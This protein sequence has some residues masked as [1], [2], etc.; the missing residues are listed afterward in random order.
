MPRTTPVV[1]TGDEKLRTEFNDF[2]W[3]DV[4]LSSD[5]EVTNIPLPYTPLVMG[6]EILCVRGFVKNVFGKE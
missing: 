3:M 1:N 5:G 6:L 2:E 4:V